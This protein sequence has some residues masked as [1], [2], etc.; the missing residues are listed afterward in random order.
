MK[1]RDLELRNFRKFRQAVRLE[2]LKDGLNLVCEPNE[3]GKSTVLE[4][5]RAVL[6]ERH[7]STSKQ[8][9][10]FLPFGDQTAPT[11]K[12]AFEI[13]TGKWTVEKRF[14]QSPFVRLEGP[15][16]Q[17]FESDAAEEQLQALLGFTKAGNTGA[18]DDT[19]GALGLLWVEQ[20]MAFRVA[21]PGEAAKKTIESVLASE[22]GAITGGRRLAAVTAVID[23][24]LAEFQTPGGKPTK[25]LAEAIAEQTRAGAETAA[26]EE[27]FRVLEEAM[28]ALD[29]QRKELTRIERDLADPE[30]EQA[31]KHLGED[32]DRAKLSAATIK[33]AEGELRQAAS[34]R[35]RLDDQRGLRDKK[36]GEL[37][38]AEQNAADRSHAVEVAT[39]A[40]AGA[41]SR[42]TEAAQRVSEAR[43]KSEADE[44]EHA[45]AAAAVRD[46]EKGRA[47]RAGSERLAQAEK[48]AAQIQ[49]LDQSVASNT[50]TEQ[51]LAQLENLERSLL[52]ATATA[53]VGAGNLEAQLEP[54]ANG[55]ARLD[56]RMLADGET[57]QLLSY[58][59]LAIEGVGRFVFSANTGAQ[60]DAAL[61]KAS[62]DVEEMLKRL[63]F[64]DAVTAKKASRDRQSAVADL[65]AAHTRLA[66]LCVAD[67][68]L[69]I[70]AGLQSLRGALADQASPSA[71]NKDLGQLRETEL[72]T[73]SASSKARAALSAEEAAHVAAI[74]TLGAAETA[75]AKVQAEHGNASSL[76]KKLAAELSEERKELS[77][78]DLQARL[79][80]ASRR[81]A[82]CE[83]ALAKSREAG[84]DL[85]PEQIQKRIDASGRRRKALET[86]RVTA[87]EG[88]ARL[89]ETVHVRGAEGPSTRRD[90]AREALQTVVARA[91]RLRDEADALALLK[92]T[93]AA[94]SLDAS[95]RYLAPVT[96]RVEPYVRRL[97]PGAS[98]T[99][100]EDMS[101]RLLERGGRS[102]PADQLSMGTQ[103]QL[104]VLT[105]IAF[106]DLL[107]E[108]GKP[109]SLVL[110][111]ALVFS[112]DVR[113]DTM[114][115]ILSEVSR[116]MQVIILTCRASLFR[117]LDAHKVRMSRRGD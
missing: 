37:A 8:I 30:F 12:L 62:Q 108:K 57:R 29:R 77:D 82:D 65:K 79:S 104:A 74:K 111:D 92:R 89:M 99:F 56:D 49:S 41:Q 63:G 48:I 114:L 10:S 106:A 40:L 96:T 38:V 102:E 91:E 87:R 50:M 97:L 27:A 75:L 66:D 86:D 39:D 93:L 100:G 15:R 34:E 19:R 4:A 107:V 25:K 78:A 67:E 6:F 116:R 14:L 76:A 94:A 35:E 17:T 88:I 113:F 28:D 73:Q 22:V 24:A 26:A 81:E 45:S 16:G 52:T 11:V 51:A 58:S 85:D 5:L 70:E 23:K 7:R 54:T 32:L 68:A 95:R 103:E 69:G 64:K 117:S 13:E 43:I 42:Q 33:V 3:T 20:G 47:L 60:A 36:V 80:E 115:E 98:L 84:A 90:G 44:T 31:A 61:K 2:G 71:T 53:S 55:K 18:T 112:D 101:P 46:H 109:A 1:I 21:P 72:K 110:D 105:R 9:Q 59:I 83:T